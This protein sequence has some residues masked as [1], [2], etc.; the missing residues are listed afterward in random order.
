MKK[1]SRKNSVSD[2]LED[3]DEDLSQNAELLLSTHLTVV[4]RARCATRGTAADVREVGLVIARQHCEGD[5]P[6]RHALQAAAERCAAQA[7]IAPSRIEARIE[8]RWVS[9]LDIANDEPAIVSKGSNTMNTA[10]NSRFFQAAALSCAGL[11][12][13][14]GATP[15]AADTAEAK[16]RQERANCVNGQTSQ[17]KRTCLREAGAALQEARRGGLSSASPAVLAQNA[18]ARCQNQPREDRADCMRLA[19]GEGMKDGTVGQGAI[20]REIATLQTDPPA[21][22]ASTPR[23]SN[24]GN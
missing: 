15:A 8:G 21:A 6:L 13:F 10:S 18:V 20:I 4:V 12:A 5:R 11:L 17:D 14:A 22:G 19:R 1:N 16:Y 7:A 3:L 2:R 24:Q 9:L 23:S